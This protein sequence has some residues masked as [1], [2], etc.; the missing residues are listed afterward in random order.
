MKWIGPAFCTGRTGKICLV[1]LFSLMWAWGC[2]PGA[3]QA[4]CDSTEA[5]EF[6]KGA[7]I[8]F[9]QEIEEQGG[10]FK[11]DGTDKDLLDVL[12]DHG[13]NYARLRIWHTPE[14]GYCGLDSTLIMAARI[15]SKDLGLL[16]DFHYSDTWADPGKQY[17][18]GAWQ[19]IGF[20]ALKDSVFEY[21]RLVVS[22][23]KNQNTLPDMVQIGNEITCG[24]LWDTGRVCGRFDTP[25]RWASLGN[26]IARGIEG[27]RAALG[28]GD[29]VSIMIHIDRGADF[30]GSI[31]FFDNLL[32]QGIDFD[33]I[34]LSYYP[35]W[36]GTMD[37]VESNLDTLARRY[38]KDIVVVETAYP[39]TLDWYDH[40]HNLVGLPGQLLPAYTATVEG[41]GAF[42]AD[43]MDIISGTPSCRGRGIFYWAPEY[44]S[45]VRMGSPWENL[46]LFDFEG[47]L[48]S[49]VAAFDSAATRAPADPR[50]GE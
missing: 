39:W 18:P 8:S 19:G 23:L 30:D 26:L 12:K 4:R 31:W 13:F 24:I 16:L 46:A 32:A 2:V 14:H 20:D 15:K 47:N 25:G 41:Q 29:S 33:I 44:I 38:R 10:V 5:A 43:L 1:A 21:T 27:V 48:L 42:L 49:S 50:R 35:W 34:G 22:R 36:H 17:K 11:E 37:R 9:L 3:P 7:D 28:P 45:T 40:V 6:I